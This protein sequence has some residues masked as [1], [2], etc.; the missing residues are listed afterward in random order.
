M[1][2]F[3]ASLAFVPTANEPK[4]EQ[5]IFVQTFLSLS[6]GKK[7][8]LAEKNLSDRK[9]HHSRKIVAFFQVYCQ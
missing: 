8:T 9:E 5:A 7:D 4:T 1:L 3:K 2:N 6:H